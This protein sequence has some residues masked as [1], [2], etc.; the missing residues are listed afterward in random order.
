VLSGHYAYFARANGIYVYDIS[1]PYSPVL[2]GTYS[3]T[4]GSGILVSGRYVYYLD[5]TAAFQLVAVD[6][7]T[8]VNPMVISRTPSSINGGLLTMNDRYIINSNGGNSA[9]VEI[10]DVSNPY[11][12]IR[13]YS[14]TGGIFPQTQAIAVQGK[15]LFMKQGNSGIKV[16]AYDISNPYDVVNVGGVGDTLNQNSGQMIMFTQGR[17]MY[18]GYYAGI[19]G[20]MEIVDISNPANMTILGV[21]TFTGQLTAV[22]GRYIYVIDGNNNLVS[23]DVGGAYIQQ[24]EVGGINTESL[25]VSA[26]ATFSQDISVQGSVGI[27]SS[28]QVSG[29]TGLS[30]GLNVQ[31]SSVLGGGLNSLATP[32]VPSVTPQGTTGAQR[33]DYTI[34]AVNAYGG[35]TLASSAGT[36]ATG[37]ATLSGT[38]FNRVAWSA[39]S[40][41]TS[42]KIYRTFT[43]GATSPTTTGLVGSTTTLTFDDTGFAAAGSAP[44]VNTTGQLTVLG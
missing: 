29:N 9:A 15:Y 34:T 4:I 43:T 30:G 1:N 41:A 24:L 26:N 13:T 31:G 21:S 33:W 5:K 10:Y 35:E 7:A 27:G 2:A 19:T 42:Y 12:P 16:D 37:N 6:F 17:F 20:S 39:V 40:G 28:L 8:P 18:V 3:A 36:T 32:S 14:V 25:G 23:Y 22:N 11:S 44:T 38:N